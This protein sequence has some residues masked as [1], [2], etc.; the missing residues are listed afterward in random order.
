MGLIKFGSRVDLMLPDQYEILVRQGD[1]LRE[2][3]T[4]VAKPRTQ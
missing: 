1:R 3:D 2:G 4:V